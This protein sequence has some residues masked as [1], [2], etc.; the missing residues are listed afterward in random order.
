VVPTQIEGPENPDGLEKPGVLD[1]FAHDTDRDV[2]VL[3]IYA[4]QPW[5][6]GFRRAFQL[7]EK[8]NAYLSFLLDGEFADA[9]PALVGKKAEIQL[10]TLHPPSDDATALIGHCREQLS[11][12]GI[13]L[14]VVSLA[15]EE[16]CGGDCGCRG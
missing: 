5:T 15:E 10:R 7:Q 11:F 2:V 1:A 8:L 9:F 13:D 14:V 16:S 3:A 12:Q 6:D 4:T